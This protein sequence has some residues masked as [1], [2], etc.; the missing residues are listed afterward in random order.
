[1]PAAKTLIK[2][3]DSRGST[4]SVKV[5]GYQ[6]KWQYDY[7]DQGVSY[8]STLSRDSNAARQLQSGID[9]TTVNE[10]LRD[11][12]YPLVVPTG[13]KVRLLLTSAD[14][15]S[16]LAPIRSPTVSGVPAEKANSLQ[17]VWSS[18]SRKTKL[19]R[20]INICLTMD[21]HFGGRGRDGFRKQIRRFCLE[22]A[23]RTT[24]ASDCAL[25]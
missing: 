19:D 21:R 2:L 15:L 11:V 25:Y 24:N 8:F 7:L 14:P 18:S 20:W 9:P 23:A 10:Y 16:H 22:A 6:W 1:M 12:D 4:L 3:E 13:A 17:C 5:T